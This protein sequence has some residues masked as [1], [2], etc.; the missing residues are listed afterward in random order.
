MLITSRI[1]ESIVVCKK[2][3]NFWDKNWLALHENQQ[4]LFIHW[5]QNKN[6][7][8]ELGEILSY[9]LWSYRNHLASSAKF[10]L[11]AMLGSVKLINQALDSYLAY[12]VLS[13]IKE[14]IGI[15]CTINKS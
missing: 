4:S 5:A 11:Q 7:S 3:H 6:A 14:V 12:Q 9:Q 1:W 8:P 15:I 2:I 13:K 10:I